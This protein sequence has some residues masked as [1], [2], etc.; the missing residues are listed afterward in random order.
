MISYHIGWSS[1]NR[2][3]IFTQIDVPTQEGL[4]V[5]VPSLASP[6]DVMKPV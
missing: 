2:G 1:Y 6:V 5:P 3:Y 4:G